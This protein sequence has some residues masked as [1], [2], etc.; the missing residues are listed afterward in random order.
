MIPK[1]IH[2]CWFGRNPLP[3]SALKCIESWRR[4][5]P[6][7]EIKRW[8][9]DNFDVNIITY[10]ADA[11]AAKKYAFVSDYAR[12]WI[13]YQYGGVY[14][15]TDVEVIK[16]IDDIIERGPFLGIEVETCD[17]LHYPMVAPGLGMAIELGHVFYKR[18]LDS[19]AK[20]VFR[21]EN[22]AVQHES[23]VPMTTRLL[24]EAGLKPQNELQQ[25]AG[26]WIY[27]KDFFNPFDDLTGRLYKT[28][29]TRTIHWYSA[30][31]QHR[32]PLRKWLSRFSHRIFGMHLHA[33]K[34]C[35]RNNLK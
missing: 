25:V 11:Y 21:F 9:E 15:D 23:I 14:F 27:P 13:L 6:D 16:P 28:E 20:T 1:I 8:D 7:Y 10:T 22:G 12:F 3:D 19:Y 33:L 2:Y 29:N 24:V 5:F 35:L 26:I 34:K 18:A 30:T 31:W 4:F 32:N 17:Q